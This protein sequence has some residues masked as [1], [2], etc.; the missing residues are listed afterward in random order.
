M[1]FYTDLFIRSFPILLKGI[2]TTV[3]VFC[4]SA[5]LSIALGLVMGILISERLQ[6]PFIS[7]SLEM[8]TFVLR[9][10]PFYVQ[11]LIVYFV[12]PD[13]TGFNLK[14]FAASVCALSICSAGYVAQ[15]VRGGINS[16]PTGQW[17]AAFS[18]GYSTLKTLIH[19]IL[20]Q[21]WRIILPSLNNEMDALI[22]ST[23]IISTIGMLELTRMGMNLVSREMEPV[24]IYLAIAVM[25]LGLSALLNLIT[26]NLERRFAY[27]KS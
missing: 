24:P 9:G 14:P 7:R 21:T 4:I 23:S 2:A 5:L 22:K 25:Y 18:L 13:L 16:L 26:R 20:P 1:D 19:V 27:A 11:L 3:E 8:I 17:E 6:T 12:L 10:V 15:L